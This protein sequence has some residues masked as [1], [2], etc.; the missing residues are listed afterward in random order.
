MLRRI[1]PSEIA[2]S[3]RPAIDPLA[4]R[5]AQA[6]TDAV[7]TE[8]EPAVRRYAERFNERKPGEP[9]LIDRA[10]MRAALDILPH[11]DRALLERVAGRIHAFAKAQRDA[12]HEVMIEVPGGRAGHT[13]EPVHTAACY[14]PAGGYPLPSTALMT[15]VTARVAGCKRVRVV[16]PGAHPVMLAAA[17]IAD[18]DEFLALGG[19]HAVAVNALSLPGIPRADVFV[20]PGNKWVTAAKQLLS[21]EIGID[22][23]AGPSELLVL[24]DDTADPATVAAD[25]L[26]Q[27]EHDPDA[28]PILVTTSPALA[29]AVD[30]EL[31]S[32]LGTLDTRDVARRALAHGYTVLAHTLEEAIAATNTVAPE[33]LEIITRDPQAVGERITNAGA[34]FLGHASAEVMGDYGAG[35]NHTLPT[36]GTARFQAGLSVIHFL[37]LRTWLDIRPDDASTLAADAQRLAGIEGLH[38]HARSAERRVHTETDASGK[39]KPT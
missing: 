39:P 19:A 20:G 33:H 15:A 35:P 1:A 12:I 2:T 29:D 28:T 27:A 7:R 4:L 9:L 36:G 31:A 18:A 21:A 25:L 8:G 26:A 3:T 30:A 14:A 22:M 24:A 13:I 10:T 17:A 5:D 38:A 16:S 34:L 6:I 37:R 11:D 23:L 32:Q